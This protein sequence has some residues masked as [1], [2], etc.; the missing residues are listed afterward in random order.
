M[1]DTWAAQFTIP[2]DYSDHRECDGCS[3]HYAPSE[4]YDACNGGFY[5]E[6]CKAEDGDDLSDCCTYEDHLVSLARAGK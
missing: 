4:L 3:F 5:C 1:T 2:T 6:D